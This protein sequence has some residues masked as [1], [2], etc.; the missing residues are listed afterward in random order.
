MM[1]CL[2]QYYV[3]LSGAIGEGWTRFWFTPGDPA[4]VSV[5]RLLSGLVVVYLH[6]TL[7]LDLIALFG[8][9][10]LLPLADIGP[11]EGAT[12]SYLNYLATPA[13]LW[14]VH[15]IGLAVL[16][17]FAA[18]L[19]TRVTSILALIVF[20]S[21]VHRAPMI[22][23]PTESVAAMVMLYLCFAPCGRRFSLDALLAARKD[24][25]AADS[26]GELSTTATIA[27]RLIQ[28][29]LALVV[30]MMGLSQLGGDVWWNGLGM[31]FLIVRGQSRLVDFTWL[32]T[33]P[34]LV[35]LWTHA[36]VFFELCFPFM[37][38]IPLARPLILALGLVIWALLAM[39]TGDI[40]FSLMLFIASLAFVPPELIRSLVD[41]SRPS[42]PAS[43]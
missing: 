2:S 11:L 22:T 18:G 12:F 39:V 27:T 17:L 21:D 37:V 5:I 13:E 43:A 38:W 24:P 40:T 31:W 26:R 41:R 33:T 8:P 32:H 4:T 35:D 36:V 29:H 34:Q 30:A 3:R 25:R 20:L 10:G 14:A 7:G 28:V 16:V 6:A 9:S 1:H 42:V 23:G 19:W 15:L